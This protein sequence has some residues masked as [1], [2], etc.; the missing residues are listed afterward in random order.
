MNNPPIDR[1]NIV[2]F[3]FFFQ[4]IGMLF[5][6][7][8]FMNAS[9]YFRLRFIGSSWA[10]N[11]Q[12]Y[13]AIAF[14]LCNCSFIALL[15]Y[16][17]VDHKF[18]L[19]VRVVSGLVM[20]GFVFLLSTML[21]AFD[22]FA[23]DSFFFITMGS[24]LLCGISTGILQKGLFGLAGEFPP[25]YTQAIMNGQGIAGLVVTLSA[26]FTTLLSS[27]DYHDVKSVNQSAF[28]Y[29]LVSL[30]VI[31]ISC[32]SFVLLTRAPIYRYYTLASKRQIHVDEKKNSSSESL[33]QK[34]TSATFLPIDNQEDFIHVEPSF[35]NVF[36]EIKWF[37]I[38]IFN[39]FFV[40]LTLF[41]SLRMIGQVGNSIPNKIFPAFVN[42]IF[43]IG[44]V[45]GKTLPSIGRI[46]IEVHM[47][48]FFNQD[49]QAFLIILVMAISN[50]Y[51]AS[52]LMMRAPQKVSNT[53][54]R[55]YAGSLMALALTLGLTAG[56]LF[57]FALRA[58]LCRCNP[59]VS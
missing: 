37:I 56:A 42:L 5:P 2:Y 28:L 35:L 59:F 27:N 20:N 16:T 57:S 17:K 10:D 12:S 52:I 38:S 51:I 21:T 47:P 4:G 44:D 6:W 7:N 24:I 48:N 49:Y 13:F 14:M 22:S 29:F 30:L 9:E 25:I 33:V 18:S 36:S 31:L 15:M 23:P 58:M 55:E 43:Q 39:I 41:P 34:D 19:P 11:F 32:A 1:F 8:V 54:F 45:I 46:K 3:I 50:G 26:I 53:L 40:T